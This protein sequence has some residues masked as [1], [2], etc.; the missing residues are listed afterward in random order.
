MGN[1]DDM[2]L[3]ALLRDNPGITERIQ[4]L[5][6]EVAKDKSKI[7]NLADKYNQ[8]HENEIIEGTRKL[9]TLITEGEKSGKT[10]QE[11]EQS[12]G[13][14]PSIYTPI[15]NWLYS[16]MQTGRVPNRELLREEQNEL[17]KLLLHEQ[18]SVER[19][20]KAPDT[21]MFLSG[22]KITH[23]QYLK[24][25]KLKRL[26]KSPNEHEAFQAYTKC[27]QLCEAFDVNFDH[28]VV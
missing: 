25:K 26:S 11:V 27:I 13:F 24:L 15:L 5:S 17:Y 21:F 20:E 2:S 3:V 1:K 28:I 4:K 22:V 6:K 19:M 16:F 7:M 12:S 23:E 18:Q 9:Q 14:I 8:E 10:R